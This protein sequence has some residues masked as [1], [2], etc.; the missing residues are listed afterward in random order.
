[1]SIHPK[2]PIQTE[3]GT[4]C[5]AGWQLPFPLC[6]GFRPAPTTPTLGWRPPVVGW[7]TLRVSLSEPLKGNCSLGKWGLFTRLLMCPRLLGFLPVWLAP[8][9]DP[10]LSPPAASPP[11]WLSLPHPAVRFGMTPRSSTSTCLCFSWSLCRLSQ[12]RWM[13]PFLA[14]TI[15]YPC[16]GGQCCL[17]PETVAC[18]FGDG[19]TYSPHVHSL[20][21]LGFLLMASARTEC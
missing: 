16:P 11:L 10:L 15:A 9:R 14:P 7:G 21:F 19:P 18:V 2:V 3:R 12:V 20:G 4:V 6:R 13:S 1:M 5:R 17:C 8:A